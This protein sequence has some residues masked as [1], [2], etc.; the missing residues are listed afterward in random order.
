VINPQNGHILGDPTSPRDV[1]FV[2]N[3]FRELTTKVRKIRTWIRKGCIDDAK[4][5]QDTRAMFPRP[6]ASKERRFRI[7]DTAT[8]THRRPRFCAGL[9]NLRQISVCGGKPI[10][11]VF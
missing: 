1:F 8:M 5:S 3:S 11:S 4:W 9:L 7:V 6:T 10:Q 2:K